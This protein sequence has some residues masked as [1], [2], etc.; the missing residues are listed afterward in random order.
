MSWLKAKQFVDLP[1]TISCWHLLHSVL[2]NPIGAKI[3]DVSEQCND[4]EQL[5]ANARHKFGMLH[6]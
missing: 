3:C 1:K 4:P 5:T 6:S 2:S